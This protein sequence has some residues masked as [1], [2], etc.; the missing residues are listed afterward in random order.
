MTKERK[1]SIVTILVLASVTSLVVFHRRADL[2]N[3][4]AGVRSGTEQTPQD[5]VYAMLDA[6][7]VGDV[8]KYLASHTGQ[9]EQSLRRAM[10]EST[11][12]ANYLRESNTAIKG[13]AIAEPEAVSPQE[14]KL[15]VEYVFQDRNEIQVMQL[16]KTQSGWKISNV[17]SAERVKTVVP[18]GTTVE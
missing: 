11:N 18:Y 4:L 14:V 2:V 12:F 6:A 17:Q 5:V 10:A 8:D 15:R 1:A 7:R 16:D 13:I 9:I 3:S